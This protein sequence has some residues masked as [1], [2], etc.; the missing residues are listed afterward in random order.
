[1]I[2]GVLLAAGAGR[3]FGGE[4]LASLLDGE[5]VARHAGRALTLVVDALWVVIAPDGD[6]VRRALDGIDACF[7]VNSRAR[8]GIGSS[9]AAGVAAL[10]ADVEGALVALADQPRIGADVLSEL[11][12]VFREGRAAIVAPS[13]RG[14]Q[15]NPVLFARSV[16]PE[17]TAL[18]GDAG[19]RAVVAR[20]SERVYLV[21]VDAPVP[22]DVDLPLDL[23]R[24]DRE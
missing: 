9:I 6:A 19:A 2:A 15:A 22:V 4:K 3:R 5:P 16:F 1:M 14:V 11:L 20:D 18:T 7:V 12:R 17:L 13:Y 24:F 10:P 23:L 21:H 8:E